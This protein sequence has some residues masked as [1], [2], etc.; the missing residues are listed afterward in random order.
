MLMIASFAA[1]QTKYVIVSADTSK[2]FSV[3]A[4]STA[5]SIPVQ[6]W[7]YTATTNQQWTLQDAGNGSYYIRNV[8]SGKALDLSSAMRGST[9]N[10]RTF[11]QGAAR[12]QWLI[13]DQ[14]NGFMEI[15]NILT[16]MKLEA[17]WTPLDNGTPIRQMLDLGGGGTVGWILVPVS[18]TPPTCSSV[19]N[20]G[21]IQVLD[22]YY[23]VYTNDVQNA[24]RLVYRTWND[25][26]GPQN[27]VISYG[28]YD[29]NLRCWAGPIDLYDGVEGLYITEVWGMATDGTLH[30]LGE[31]TVFTVKPTP[32]TALPP[33]HGGPVEVLP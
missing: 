9:V 25:V 19:T 6:A 14:G 4:G 26:E 21:F 23:F 3:K 15:A 30:W 16:K 27:A 11:R 31:S 1:A 33:R 12:Q 8:A 22:R 2:V 20:D 18:N 10:V 28:W 24:V 32:A 17:S 7:D 5:S 13:N 29:T